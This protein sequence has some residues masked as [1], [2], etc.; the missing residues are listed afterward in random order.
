MYHLSWFLF[1]FI[2]LHQV[3]LKKVFL[4][5]HTMLLNIT[6]K[7]E[8]KFNEKDLTKYTLLI[9]QILL[10]GVPVICYACISD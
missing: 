6:Y 5:Y 4:S 1:K 9:G 10:R 3:L 8:N 2:L 7:H